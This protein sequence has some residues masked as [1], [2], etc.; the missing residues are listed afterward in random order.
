[1]STADNTPTP[2]SPAPAPAAAATPPNDLA[3]AR[4]EVNR[5]HRAVSGYADRLHYVSSVLRS[6]GKRLVEETAEIRMRDLDTATSSVADLQEQ[7][8]TVDANAAT[9]A[10]AVPSLLRLLETDHPGNYCE[11]TASA[12]DGTPVVI[13]Y[14]RSDRPTPHDLRLEAETQRDAA[15]G[16]VESLTKNLSARQATLERTAE[17]RNATRDAYLGLILDADTITNHAEACGVVSTP[18]YDLAVRRVADRTSASP[19]PALQGRVRELEQQVAEREQLNSEDLAKLEEAFALGNLQAQGFDIVLAQRDARIAELEDQDIVP[20]IDAALGA[21]MAPT[22]AGK[23][24]YPAA[25]EDLSNAL[26][27]RFTPDQL[28]ILHRAMRPHASA[29][30]NAHFV[31]LAAPGQADPS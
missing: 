4:A 8:K 21:W 10:E 30:F 5:L 1:M 7:V 17:E 25:I 13:T 31:D 26:A 24:A 14:Q 3:V 18:T 9:I 29:G 19:I 16:R 2:D 12:S 27:R 6:D 28:A 20:R 23:S 11:M 15:L 22:A